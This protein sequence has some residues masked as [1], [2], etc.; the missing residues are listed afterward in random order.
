MC[1]SYEQTKKSRGEAVRARMQYSR[2][3][4]RG[5]RGEPVGARMQYSSDSRRGETV[6]ARSK[7]AVLVVG[8]KHHEPSGGLQ[9]FNH[10]NILK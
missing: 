10:T 1:I 5:R 6:R 8:A 4:R 3:N 7:K 9:F 2:V